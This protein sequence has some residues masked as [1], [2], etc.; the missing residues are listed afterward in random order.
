[1]S[2]VFAQS[3][4]TVFILANMEGLSEL[5]ATHMKFHDLGRALYHPVAL[6]IGDCGY[7]NTLGHWNPIGNITS[8]ESL[9]KH[10]LKTVQELDLDLDRAPVEEGHAWGPV[11]AN[12]VKGTNIGGGVGAS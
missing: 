4:V 7:F 9:S 2:T 10:K 11:L 6:K 8:S 3:V 5:Y 12:D 1:M